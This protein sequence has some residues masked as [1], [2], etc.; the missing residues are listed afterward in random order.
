M[1]PTGVIICGMKVGG[2]RFELE[3]REGKLKQGHLFLFPQHWTRT[4]M[5][6][7]R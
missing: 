7:E 3:S 5:D 6:K 2:G 4:H 1:F